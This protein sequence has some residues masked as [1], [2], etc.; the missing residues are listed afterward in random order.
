MSREIKTYITFDIG[1]T[2]I[3]WAVVTS[4]FKILKNGKFPFDA[5]NRDCKSEMI[6]EIGKKINDLIVE[7]NNIEG[8]GISTAGDVDPKTTEI[9]GCTPNHKNYTGVIFKEELSKYTDLPLVI[10]ND[11]NCAIL[12]ESVRGQLIG[13]ENAVMITLG[14]DIGTGILI[15]K[16]V[17]TS[18]SGC[19]ANAGYLNILGRRWGTYFSSIGLLRLAKEMKNADVKEPIEVLNNREF[20]EVSN[21][22]YE[23]LSIGIAN[24]IAIL[25][26]RMFVIGGGI[27]E[28][29]AIDLNKI[30]SIVNKT[31]I[32]KHLINAC[33]I[34]LSTHGNHSAI[35]GC[36]QLLNDK[37]GQ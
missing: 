26:P 19:A 18:L 8:I 11:A 4:D 2:F 22:W 32:E 21:Y 5:L 36:V 15:D 24:I 34:E 7:F 9:I 25:S 33:K 17:F 27:S 31:L 35:Y 13:V 1:G 12:G 20:E 3:K 10:D 14:T 28:S 16:K 6:G 37:L 29:G 23:G 30:Q